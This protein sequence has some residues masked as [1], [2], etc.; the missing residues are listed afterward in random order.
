[1]EGG[2]YLNSEILDQLYIRYYKSTLLYI[3]S[4][5]N[6]RAIAEDIVEDA[7][8]KAYLSFSSD[9]TSFQFW[10][11]RVSKNLWI[12]YLRRQKRNVN[13]KDLSL[14]IDEKCAPEENLLKNEW[15][16]TMYHCIW[17]LSPIEREVLMLHYFSN[18]PLREIALMLKATPG[19][20]KTR[21]FRARQN[22]K[23]LMEDNGYDI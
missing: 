18:L 6:D 23:K 21:I 15:I 7:F 12:D 5:C 8:V 17:L 13:N 4:L 9:Y 11:L 20:I 2:K 10:L 1:M 3:L 16:S 14:V 19:S 22:L